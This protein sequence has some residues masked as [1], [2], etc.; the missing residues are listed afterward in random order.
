MTIG[1]IVDSITNGQTTQTP[2]TQEKTAMSSQVNN[3][4][5][6]PKWFVSRKLI[7]G[8]LCC[9]GKWREFTTFGS[10]SEIKF[11][12]SEKNAYKYG[13]RNKEGTAYSV[14]PDETVDAL[15]R[16]YRDE[17]LVGGIKG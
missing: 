13:L 6:K 11:Y 3:D 16:V 8:F 17:V 2:H 7:G 4:T 12:S 10:R 15:G 9:D 1:Q 14:Y 5:T